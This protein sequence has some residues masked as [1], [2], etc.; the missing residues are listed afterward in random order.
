MK[1]FFVFVM[2]L[3][4]SAVM[5]AGG[6]IFEAWVT[7]GVN[8][9]AVEAHQVNTDEVNLGVIN[10][11]QIDSFFV[12][13]WQEGGENFD[14][15]QVSYK[16]DDGDVQ[17]IVLKWKKD[18]SEKDREW[19]EELKKDLASELADGDHSLEMWFHG[20]L[21]NGE[22][23][24][25]IYMNND[26]KNYKFNFTKGT[27]E[28]KVM[29]W[30]IK[31]SFNDWESGFDMEQ[32]EN[33]SYNVLI[34]VEA[35]ASYEFKIISIEIQGEKKDTTWYGLP[36]EGNVMSYGKSTD[37]VAYKSEGENN[38]A[39]VGLKT[40]TKG[41]YLF[42]VDPANKVDGKTAPV[43]SVNIPEPAPDTREK[44]EI[45]LVPGDLK[46]SNPT[47][48][49]HAFS[50]GKVSFSA[51]M[52]V[53]KE[54][55]DTVAYVAEIPQEL[56]SLI[57]VRAATEVTVWDD[58]NWDEGGN[59]WNQTED[60]L[61][62][63]DTARFVDWV[64]ETKYFKV[65][66]C[67]ACEKPIPAG[68]IL[69]KSK[70]FDYAANMPFEQGEGD[71]YTVK[72]TYDKALKD[73][74]IIVT[75]E[76]LYKIAADAE[77]MHRENCTD[78]TLVED[79][80]NT[81]DVEINVDAPGEYTYIWKPAELK[82]S[83]IYPDFKLLGDEYFI[84]LPSAENPEDWTWRDME[85]DV[86]TNLWNYA[87]TWVDG[88]ANI[89]IGKEEGAAN[90]YFGEDAIDFGANL[91][92]PSVGTE[93]TYTWNPETQKLSVQYEKQEG[94]E[95]VYEL[96]LNAPMFNL[97]GVEVDATFHGIVIQNGHKYI[98]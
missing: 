44:R 45:V 81:K 16:L 34:P 60:L 17:D 87:T 24:Q 62:G 11:F 10:A 20:T 29:S 84:K 64:Y 3:C 27:P 58:L 9:E 39:N 14:P 18:L 82:I 90:I 66:W 85:K 72:V 71:V 25:E 32:D 30:A 86:D 23:T 98:R 43:F 91:V 94:I 42:S 68:A 13:V 37:W 96:D 63:C 55:E 76:K 56:D 54:G 73:E 57:F 79:G 67:D 80:E 15:V 95:A 88:G 89:G 21:H 7:Y 83:V 77:A 46:S 19:A 61:I 53:K 31:G 74:F 70:A 36:S 47:M 65:C 52:S 40:T 59:V 22:N 35:E 1:K 78:W 8:G 4:C 49:V 97:L 26:G 51:T 93:C 5:Y 69:F 33:G 2:A 28:P 38:Q 48:L 41:D 12:K 6:G 75:S 92:K 50:L